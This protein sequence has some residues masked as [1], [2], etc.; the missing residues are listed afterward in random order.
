MKQRII[1]GLVLA[2]LAI[3]LIMIG[4]TSF[5]V[6]MMALVTVGVVE[7][8]QLRKIKYTFIV[9]IIVLIATY[10]IPNVS[11]VMQL[12]IISCTFLLLGLIHI[13]DELFTLKDC[14][15]NIAFVFL[16]GSALSGGLNLYTL[17][18][19]LAILWLFIANY[20]SDTGA[21]FAGSFFGKHKLNK[22]LSPKKTVEGSIGGWIFGFAISLVFGL[23]FLRSSFTSNFL[24]VGSLLLPLLAQMGDLFFSSIKRSYNVKDF[25]SLFPGHGGVLDRIDS[26]V[27]SMFFINL[28]LMIWSLL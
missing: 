8:Y 21:Y 11:S 22:R 18:G 17:E 24:L 4:Q 20:G 7:L 14:L 26:L 19:P 13:I 23:V 15:L 5:F 10:L 27:F 6:L 9:P 2:A 12:I 28:L 16:M 25:G 1:T 3:T